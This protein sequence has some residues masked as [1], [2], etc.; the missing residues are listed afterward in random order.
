MGPLAALSDILAAA[1]LAGFVSDPVA[2]DAAAAADGGADAG[3][4][5]VDRGGGGN[6]H[7]VVVRLSIRSRIERCA[8]R[9]LA[10]QYRLARL[11]RRDLLDPR[12]ADEVGRAHV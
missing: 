4:A 1:A 7:L 3:A 2:A 9:A 10:P 12:G 11:A 6:D 8:R 5:L